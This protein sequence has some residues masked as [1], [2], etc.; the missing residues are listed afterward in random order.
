MSCALHY[1]VLVCPFAHS[2]YVGA[3]SNLLLSIIT[4]FSSEFR[5]TLDGYSENLSSSELA[6]GTHASCMLVLCV[7][8]RALL[9]VCMCVCVD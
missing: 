1:H 7:C 5:T 6:G 9:C 2:V 4:D 3:Q 8:S